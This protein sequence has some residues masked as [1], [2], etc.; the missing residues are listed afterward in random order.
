MK[1]HLYPFS[2]KI[3]N[4]FCVQYKSLL[5]DKAYAAKLPLMFWMKKITIGLAAVIWRS[6]YRSTSQNHLI[7]HKLTIIFPYGSGF[8]FIIR[9]RKIS[10]S[11][12]FPALAPVKKASCG[13]PF[14][15]C[16]QT[17]SF[18]RSKSRGFVKINMAD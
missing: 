4:T 1:F 10:A 17:H 13:F 7:N 12:P 5:F 14:C 15:F 11:R 18:P 3:L 9:I 8:L 16:G 2:I 6:C